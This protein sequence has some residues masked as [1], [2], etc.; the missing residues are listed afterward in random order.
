MDPQMDGNTEPKTYIDFAALSLVGLLISIGI[1]VYII[2]GL[3]MALLAQSFRKLNFAW[4][5]LMGLIYLSGFLLRGVR[6]CIMLSPFK[7]LSIKTTTEGVIVGYAA[8]NILPAK[9]G[10]V[11]RAMFLSSKEGI[12]RATTFGTIVIERIFDGL[13]ILLILGVS[14]LFLGMDTVKQEMV[15]RLVLIGC[16]IFGSALLLVLLGAKYRRP[17]EKL[18]AFILKHLPQPVSDK[19]ASLL[20]NFWDSLV[21][22]RS[23][24]RILFVSIL[25]ILIWSVEGLVF[26]VGFPAFRL[27]PNILLAYFT[28]AFVNLG[29]LLPS[30]PAG[31]GV[32]Q[33]GNILAFSLFGIGLEEA[34]SYSIVVHF[35][36]IIPITI[37]GLIILNREGLAL[38]NL[39][40]TLRSVP[41]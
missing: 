11:V 38:L 37:V 31:V 26:L 21:G 40:R 18:L 23:R 14:S 35:V 29:M 2:H 16:L 1:I 20:E 33:G 10:E 8:N 30:A 34:L 24:K 4:L 12:G 32:F 39:K 5:F 17:V 9:A 15:N 27:S 6:W 36:M 7:G 28:L 13:T 19:A 41:H 3:D 25:S 22:L